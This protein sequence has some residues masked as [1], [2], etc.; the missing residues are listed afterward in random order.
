MPLKLFNTLSRKIEEFQPI[1]PPKVGF[2]A[3]GP[4]V[5]DRAHIGNLRAYIFEDILR[6]TLI[7]N[8]CQVKLVMNIT[9]VGHLTS[10]ADEGE[11]KL[12]KGAKRENSSVFEIAE[13]YTQLFKQ[14]LKALNIAEPDVWLKATDHIPEQIELI[15][16]LEAKGFTYKTSDGIYYDTSKFPHYGDLAKLNVKGQKEGARVEVNQEKRN[17]T[18]FALWKFSPQGQKRQMEWESPWGVGFPGWHIECSAMSMKALGESFD[19]HTGGVDH[20]PVHHTNEIAQSEG[21]TGRRFVKYWLH[22]E[23]LLVDSGK[24]AKSAGNFFTLDD[25]Q[26]KGFSP[27][28]YRYFVL[29]AHYRSKLNFT[30]EGLKAS[31]NAHE[32]LVNRL[33]NMPS[34][35]KIGCAD[36]ENNF[37][38][39]INNDLNTP[40]GLAVMWEM[41][42]SDNPDSAKKASLLKMDEILGLGLA[43]VNPI[44]IPKEIKE[45]VEKREVARKNKDFKLSD[46]I[47]NRIVEKGFQ[48]EDTEGGPLVRVR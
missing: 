23:F 20:I 28:N 9:D 35:A 33:A 29:G 5:Y 38:E 2:Y 12:E 4:T 25:L 8:G 37:F 32:E 39:A 34:E 36:F 26:E 27:L 17:P 16:K 30:L 41:L 46:E 10:D 45:L 3:C 13:K 21:A 18:D 7:H 43:K 42:K 47:R 31:Q 15:K 14:D 11:D 48:V 22:N 6:R 40:Q 19:I 24:M 44:K 1:R